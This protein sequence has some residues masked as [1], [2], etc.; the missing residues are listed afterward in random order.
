MKLHTFSVFCMS[1]IYLPYPIVSLIIK[2]QYRRQQS[3]GFSTLTIL[4]N[5][6]KPTS[7]TM[8]KLLIKERLRQAR[9]SFNIALSLT[10]ISAIIIVTIVALLLSGKISERTAT[11]AGEL[12]SK[13]VIV[14][15]KITKYTN[16]KC[17]KTATELKD[18]D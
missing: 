8:E 2:C 14:A 9:L 18:E 6:Q 17:D 7:T 11:T 15:I 13:L 10:K 12:A 4:N 1:I 5:N 16:E 3:K